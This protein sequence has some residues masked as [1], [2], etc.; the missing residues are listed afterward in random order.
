MFTEYDFLDR[1]KVAKRYGFSAVEIQFPYEFP[2]TKV[3]AAKESAGVEITLINIGVGDLTTGGPG[4]AAH[5]G[6]EEQ[7]K[8]SVEEAYK[9]ADS[10]KPT[11]VNVLAG[12]P[13]LEKFERR[14][15]LDVLASNLYYAADAFEKIGTKVLTEAVNTIDRPGF[16]LHST[17]AAIEI[18]E[19]AGHKNLA[20]QYDVYHMQIM[21]GNLVNT[22]RDNL[23][24]IGH[25]QFAD[26]PGRHEPGTGEINFPNLFD[27]IDKMGWKGWLG[28]EYIPSKRTEKTL[29]WMP[30]L[31][32]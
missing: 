21:E 26:T 32:T 15:C 31:A 28:A 22:I 5:P 9:Y 4:I 27:A 2:L 19:R 23:D 25:I 16:L 29:G 20:I 18:I 6:R 8:V 3:L 14:Q 13:S 17:A 10:L 7:F 24:Q 11:S 30:E 1:F 12:T